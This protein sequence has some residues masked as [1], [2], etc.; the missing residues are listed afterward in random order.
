MYENIHNYISGYLL[1]VLFYS[2]ITNKDFARAK[3]PR[4][5]PKENNVALNRNYSQIEFI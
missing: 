4:S 5:G 2:S 1:I 3:T